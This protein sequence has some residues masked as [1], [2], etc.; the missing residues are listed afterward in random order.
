MLAKYFDALTSAYFKTAKDGRH[1]FCPWGIWGTCY[2]I[3]SEPEYESRRRQLRSYTIVSI[4]L[5]IGA[6]AAFS[7]YVPMAV[8]VLALIAFY[9]VW[10]R[11]LLRGLQ[12]STER[13][14]LQEATA[15]QALTHSVTFLWLLEI[16]SLLFVATGIAML[17]F[18]PADWLVALAAIGFFGLCAVVGAYM[19]VIRHRDVTS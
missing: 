6:G 4:V 5:I 15:T 16:F 14:S 12:A 3:P 10:V 7:S 1:L 2:I 13:L 18:S 19:L 8:V 17:I 9:L 11:F